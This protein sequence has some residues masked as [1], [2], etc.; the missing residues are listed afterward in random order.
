MHWATISQ[1]YEFVKVL[2]KEN[3]PVD[4]KDP[5]G[6]TPCDWAVERGT[7]G[8]YKSLLLE[9]K[10]GEDRVGKN[11]FSKTNTNR[12]LVIISY[13]MIPISFLIFGK[14]AIYFSLP[15]VVSVLFLVQKYVIVSYLFAFDTSQI[16]ASSITSGICQATLFYVGISWCKLLVSTSYFL[17]IASYSICCYCLYVTCSKDPG[18]LEVETSI[19]A[20]T[21]V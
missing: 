9:S 19:E 1:H 2:I 17:F 3:A 13:V 6:K 10:N 14:M 15:I 18:Y 12:I 4:I 20:K 16:Q 21:R 5:A 7:E 11:P 8:I